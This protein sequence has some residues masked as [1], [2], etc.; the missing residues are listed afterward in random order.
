MG[1]MVST[2]LGD[3][4]KQNSSYILEYN[5]GLLTIP[6]LLDF[7]NPKIIRQVGQRPIDAMWTS[8]W[9]N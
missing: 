6:A 5:K 3:F 9:R 1:T 8:F 7:I 4:S 2:Q